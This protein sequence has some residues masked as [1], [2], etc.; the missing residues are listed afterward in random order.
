MGRKPHNTVL[1]KALWLS[2]ALK[3]LIDDWKEMNEMTGSGVEQ[4]TFDLHLERAHELSEGGY[5]A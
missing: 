5:A 4:Q 3:D 1:G 2:M